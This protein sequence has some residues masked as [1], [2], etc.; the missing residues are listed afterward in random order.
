MKIDYG[1]D[2]KGHVVI[3]F[4]QPAQNLL[5][6]PEQAEQMAEGIKVAKAKLAEYERDHPRG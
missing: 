3:T 1:H 5:L 6:T 2:D 4:N